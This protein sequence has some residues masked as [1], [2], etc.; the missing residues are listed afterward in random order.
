MWHLWNIF[1]QKYQWWF[2]H[3]SLGLRIE[4]RLEADLKDIKVQVITANIQWEDGVR[5]SEGEWRSEM[6]S[7]T[8][9]YQHLETRGG[10]RG[11]QGDQKGPVWKK[12]E[13]REVK[14]QE[15]QEAEDSIML[16]K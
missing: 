3:G 5:V 9:E 6:K 4:N 7:E 1:Y 2:G 15:F 8:E 13:P 12:T 14:T 16:G 11:K 10:G